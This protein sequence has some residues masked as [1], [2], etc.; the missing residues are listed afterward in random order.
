[1][2]TQKWGF[3]DDTHV[4]HAEQPISS[5]LPSSL[6]DIWDSG[7]SLNGSRNN[8]QYGSP[9]ARVYP[10]HRYA[11]ES[12]PALQ[13]MDVSGDAYEDMSFTGEIEP[14][15]GPMLL[16]YYKIK[17]HQFR[18]V[19]FKANE[20]LNLSAGE[21]VLTEADRGYDVGQIIEEIPKPPARELK[22]AK[23]IVRKA[24]ESEIS[25]LS[26]KEEREKRAMELCQ[27]KAHEM[28]LPMKIIGAV[29]QFD[30]KKLI[31]YYSANCYVDFRNL[32]RALFKIFATRIWMVW[33]NGTL[34]GPNQQF[35]FP[36]AQN[37]LPT[38]FPPQ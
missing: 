4:Q 12:A 13:Y 15:G 31:F 11:T 5:L 2:N 6:R 27:M 8:H 20:N 17:F 34:L 16:K 37:N 3:I 35:A 7:D 38:A 21:F 10:Q 22:S 33:Q 19:I 30:G 29:F 32:V 25:Q 1:M 36:Q 18:T 14:E 26:Q 23:N 9:G 28:G 24:V